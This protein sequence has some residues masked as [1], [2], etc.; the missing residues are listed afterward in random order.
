MSVD[1]MPTGRV[2]VN[3]HADPVSAGGQGGAVTDPRRRQ[4]ILIAMCL[5][6]MAVIAS[7]SGLNV[8][9]GQL[10]VDL[11]RPRASCCG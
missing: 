6:L 2:P 3:G 7:V 4:L 11:G 5:A 8:A 10:A 9:Q 1:A